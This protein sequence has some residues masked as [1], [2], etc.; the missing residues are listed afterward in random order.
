MVVG[1]THIGSVNLHMC[2]RG[3]H[4]QGQGDAFRRIKKVL[5]IC[6]ETLWMIETIYL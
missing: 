5:A 3:A 6:H 2:P 4:L 1:D